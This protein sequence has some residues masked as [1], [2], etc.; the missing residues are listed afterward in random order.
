MLD[1]KPIVYQQ[2]CTVGLPCYYE[3]IVSKDTE[4]PCI[5]YLEMQN[6][7][8]EEGNTLGY[9]T[10]RFSIKVW[11][12]DVRTLSQT[13]ISIDEKMRLLGFSRVTTS[14][15]WLDGIGQRQLLYSCKAVEKFNQ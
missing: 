6:M 7:A 3:L 15:L 12:K 11:A 2:L 13:S 9:S 4:L 10:I 8:D 14:E 5:T 1:L